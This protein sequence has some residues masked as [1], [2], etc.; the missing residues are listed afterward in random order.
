MAEHKIAEVQSYD[1]M[2][3]RQFYASVVSQAKGVL[4][5]ER[6]LI[7]NTANISSLLFYELNRRTPNL[8]NWAGFYFV[9]EGE[10]V[11]GP[12]QGEDSL[13]T[14][15]RQNSLYSN[16]NWQRCLRNCRGDST[17]TSTSFWT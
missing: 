7:A 3:K 11:L 13:I 9:K 4:E 8:I 2:D 6:D 15:W 14:H 12:F 5:G 17:N 10:L 16:Q 1:G